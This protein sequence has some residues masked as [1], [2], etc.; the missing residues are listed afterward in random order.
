MTPTPDDHGFAKLTQD[1]SIASLSDAT[2]FEIFDPLPITPTT[3]VKVDPLEQQPTTLVVNNLIDLDLFDPTVTTDA[4]LSVAANVAKTQVTNDNTDLLNVWDTEF[5]SIRIPA[6]S[7]SL[8]DELDRLETSTNLMDATEHGKND[9]SVVGIVSLIVNELVGNVLDKVDSKSRDLGEVNLL[10]LDAAENESTVGVV[11]PSLVHELVDV[12]VDKVVY[13]EK[14]ENTLESKDFDPLRIDSLEVEDSTLIVHSFVNELVDAAVGKVESDNALETQ[15]V[16]DIN[17]N[18]TESASTAVVAPLLNELLDIVLY[19]IDESEA[20]ADMVEVAMLDIQVKNSTAIAESLVNDIVEAV[21]VETPAVLE[22]TQSLVVESVEFDEI[23]LNTGVELELLS[24]SDDLVDVN[25]LEPVVGDVELDLSLSRPVAV[26]EKPKLDFPVEKEEQDISATLPK[27]VAPHIFQSFSVNALADDE[28]DFVDEDLSDQQQQPTTVTKTQTLLFPPVE[29][30]EDDFG[31]ISIASFHPSKPIL[32]ISNQ[33][34][35]ETIQHHADT[36][37][38][39]TS[40]SD[41]SFQPIPPSPTAAD[42]FETIPRTTTTS[43]NDTHEEEDISVITHFSS[44]PT[45]TDLSIDSAYNS[46]SNITSPD[47]DETPKTAPHP[48]SF[49]SYSYDHDYEADITTTSTHGE[50]ILEPTIYTP[51]APETESGQMEDLD[52]QEEPEHA[53]EEFMLN[54]AYR[55]NAVGGEFDNERML[56]MSQ[57]MDMIDSV[58]ELV[59]GVEKIRKETGDMEEQI[60]LMKE[61][62]ENMMRKGVGAAVPK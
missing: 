6:G 23:P 2:A 25:L 61:V 8:Q 4:S 24:S 16:I 47:R 60:R 32:N 55:S 11:A 19:Q 36:V 12:T 41:L 56:L 9:E 5:D 3:T 53:I 1:S 10:G 29:D 26:F 44:T 14:V 20:K 30:D 52:I 39:L 28:D 18:P 43:N 34:E 46:S 21:I 42:S 50:I 13:V 17:I 45:I 51:A 35:L 57:A 22:E 49:S 59:Y 38:P 15:D 54:P 48:L 37:L 40:S 33:L 62:I 58:S 27:S 31:D 7:L